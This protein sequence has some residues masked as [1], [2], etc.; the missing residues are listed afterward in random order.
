MEAAFKTTLIERGFKAGEI[1]RDDGLQGRVDR[2]RRGALELADLVQDHV[3]SGDVGV[4]PDLGDRCERC[5]LVRRVGVRVDED[6]RDRFGAALQEAVRCR[7]HLFRIDGDAYGPI[8][9]R[10]LGDL[11]TQI[12]FRHRFERA[13]QAPRLAAITATH[14]EHVA[15]SRRGD[16]ADLGAL[17]FEQRIRADRRAV[18]DAGEVRHG[19]ERAEASHEAL[20]FVAALGGDFGN[21]ERARRRIEQ[22]EV[23]ECAADIDADHGA[24][25]GLG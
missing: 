25:R 11:D 1:A 12:T 6:D 20:G 21:A 15:E 9:E 16:Y 17:A 5:L 23:R 19:T 7:L 24:G 14:F 13:P 18:N 10:A 3:R 4:R 2:R 8:G 22:E